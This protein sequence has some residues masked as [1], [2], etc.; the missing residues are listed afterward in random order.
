MKP[1]QTS[2]FWVQAAVIGSLYAALTLLLS[3]ISYGVMQ[4]RISEALT[5]LAM[6]T[7]AAIPGLAAGCFFAN[8]LGPNGVLDA[9]LGSLATLVGAVGTYRLRRRFCWAPM[10]PVIANALIVGLMLY[11]VY[12]VPFSPFYCVFWV[13][14][15]E[16]V[17]CY[18]IGLPLAR[19]LKKRRSDLGL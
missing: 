6:F 14:L 3:P 4:V 5:V 8:F 12:G 16:L 15:G 18:G 13:G 19:F 17:S 7:P 1:T 2:E 9:V 11:Y 10:P